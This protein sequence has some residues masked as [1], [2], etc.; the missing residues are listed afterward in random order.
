MYDEKSVI[1]EAVQNLEF[2]LGR[3][4]KVMVT[5]IRLDGHDPGSRLVAR[6]LRDACVEVIYTASQQQ[7]NNVVRQAMDHDFDAIGISSLAKDYLLVPKLKD[8]KI[9][10]LNLYYDDEASHVAAFSRW[11]L[12]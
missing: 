10:G 8:E 3:R 2:K 4:P 11:T 12:N 5:K 1:S 7:I 6:F 9:I